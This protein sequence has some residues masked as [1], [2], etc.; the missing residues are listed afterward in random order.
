VLGGVDAVAFV[1]EDMAAYGDLIGSFS[2]SLRFLGI[3]PAPH[4]QACESVLKF[5]ED[6]SRVQSYG[7][8]FD[9]WKALCERGLGYL[10]I[11]PI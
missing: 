2:R 1:T 8:R 6:D 5:T 9:K 4:A 3:R 11:A 10:G 7:L